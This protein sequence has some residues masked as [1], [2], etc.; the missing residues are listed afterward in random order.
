MQSFVLFVVALLA[1]ARAEA[2]YCPAPFVTVGKGCYWVSTSPA[3]WEDARNDCLSSP[4][5]LET[6]LAMITD[7]EEHHHFWNYVAYTL[8]QKVDYWLGGYDVL[9]EGKWQW[10]NGRD[11]PMGVPFWYPGEPSGTLGEDFLAF[12][13]EGFFAD[14]NE[15]ALLHYACQVVYLKND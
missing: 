2:E 6:D 3:T 10:L 11:V 5:D 8:G 9:E 1:V 15:D 13:K 14:Q 7:C 12:T 4:I